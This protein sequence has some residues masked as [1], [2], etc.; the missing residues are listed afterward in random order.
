[1][2]QFAEEILCV[3]QSLYLV[4]NVD[5]VAHADTASHSVS[6]LKHLHVLA[7]SQSFSEAW[8]ILLSTLVHGT[9]VRF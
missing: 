3:W 8:S 7:Q 6:A 2:V 5:V 1:V 9:M 4:V